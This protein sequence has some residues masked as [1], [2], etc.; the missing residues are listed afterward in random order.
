MSDMG[1]SENATFSDLANYMNSI[2]LGSLF[3]MENGKPTG[4]LWETI[5]DGVT[6]REEL[7]I[8]LQDTDEF[9]QRF[10]L[11]IEQ[12]QQA[13]AGT[14]TGIVLS[15]ENILEFESDVK[16]FMQAAGLPASFYDEP[17]D[18]VDLMRAGVSADQV[19]ERINIAFDT[20]ANAPSDVR[21]AFEDYFGVG[22]SDS[23]LAAYV[24]D[25]DMLTSRL[26]KERNMAFASAVGGRYDIELSKALASD[27]ATAAG[28][29]EQVQEGMTTLG[30]R[31]ALFGERIGEGDSVSAEVE[32]AASVFGVD[33]GVSQREAQ[34]EI[35]R[36]L[37]ERQRLGSQAGGA[38]LTQEG[39][40][41]LG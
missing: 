7:Y 39:V 11:I 37:Q 28:S 40:T 34:E 31:A 27:I 5:K 30:Q 16:E 10:P 9:K 13:A 32:G 14:F 36:V 35:D 25:P 41:G 3:S 15:P 33:T 22:Q 2:G 23:A 12:Q 6:T 4:W 18:F 26:E 19:G 20:I 17:S 1:L 29:L 8:K 21:D 24:L 38:V